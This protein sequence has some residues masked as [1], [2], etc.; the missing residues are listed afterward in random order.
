[1]RK[2]MV[3]LVRS[4]AALATRKGVELTPP[5]GKGRG[6]TKETQ[7]FGEGLVE[8][9]IKRVFATSSYAYKTIA[10]P[11]ARSAFWFLMKGK[12]A[13]RVKA[14]QSAA[15][16]LR[17]HSSNTRM[18]NAPIV[19]TPNTA[20]HDQARRRGRVSKADVKQ[21]VT[22]EPELKRYIKARQAKVGFLAAG[23]MAAVEELKVS[24]IPSWIKRHGSS[25]SKIV[26]VHSRTAF[27][28]LI[29]NRVKFGASAQLE[30][31]VPYALRAAREGMA[32]QAQRILAKRLPK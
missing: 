17:D 25:S 23:W 22:R 27:A 28:L 19:E 32:A 29:V 13:D 9:D 18:R 30:R 31:I 8:R 3:Q 6:T 26:P 12:K 14:H 24:K 15:A 20:L 4:G 11:A 21:I 1:M 10:N 2:N 16:I 7:R 5:M